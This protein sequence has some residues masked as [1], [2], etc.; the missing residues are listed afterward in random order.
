MKKY[1]EAIK[2]CDKSYELSSEYLDAVYSKAFCFEEMG[3]YKSAYN[4]WI[5]IIESLKK[6][7]YDVEAQREEKRAQACLEKIKQ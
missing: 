4:T 5:E 7:G 3:D 6:D 1:D 2:C